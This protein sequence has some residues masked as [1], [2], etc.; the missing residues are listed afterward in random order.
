MK[1]SH[2]D[3]TGLEHGNNVPG[4][5][6]V[7]PDARADGPTAGEPAKKLTADEQMDLY[8]Q[9]LKENDWGHQ[10]C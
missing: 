4:S 6:T 8:E 3:K 7:T 1:S 2:P 9:H 5:D 10:P